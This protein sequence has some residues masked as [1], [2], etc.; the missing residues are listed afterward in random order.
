M[1]VVEDQIVVAQNDAPAPMPAP[2]ANIQTSDAQVLVL[3]QTGGNSDLEIMTAFAL[4][5]SGIAAIFAFRR[6]SV[7]EA[8]R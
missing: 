1:A 5:G 4:L 3:P 8:N 6:K 7:V 2:D